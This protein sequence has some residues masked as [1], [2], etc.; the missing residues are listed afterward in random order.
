MAVDPAVRR[1]QN[2]INKANQRARDRAR[3]A[4][5]PVPRAVQKYPVTQAA[6]RAFNAKEDA[7][8]RRIGA[9]EQLPSV[10]SPTTSIQVTRDQPRAIAGFTRKSP[11]RQA[12]ALRESARNQKL[13]AVGSGRRQQ[14]LNELESTEHSKVYNALSPGQRQRFAELSRRLARGSNQSI[15]ILF[16]YQGGAATYNSILSDLIY[17]DAEAI[18]EALDGLEELADLGDKARVMYSPKAHPELRNI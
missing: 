15:A 4:G 2:R 13:S 1:E 11:T 7:L 9:L 10:L 14:L 5:T 6:I 17:P 16:E 8:A 3:A 12:A 18:D